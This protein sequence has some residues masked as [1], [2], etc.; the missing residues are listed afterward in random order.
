MTAAAMIRS[1]SLGELSVVQ[2]GDDV[3]VAQGLGSCVGIAAYDPVQKIAAVAHVMLPEA[4]L[5]L[6]DEAARPNPD[7]PARYAAQAVD[8]IV[9]A[10]VQRGGRAR[11]LV[12]KIAGGAQ[13]LRLAGKEDRLKIG[14]RNIAAVH[15][16]L[17]RQGL[18]VVAEDTGGNNGRTLSLYAATGI[19]TVRLVGS[20][21]HP[22]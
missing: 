8:A 2:R 12:V 15:A 13:V 1:T 14:L 6:A 19:I 10:V 7:Q 3:L 22:L 17:A 11:G 21:E 4:P 5:F 18:R 9:A 16:A 20:T